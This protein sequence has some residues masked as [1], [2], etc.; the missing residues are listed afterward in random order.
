MV[1]EE[2]K[3]LNIS[4]NSLIRNSVDENPFEALD[5]YK[6]LL[7]RVAA[8]AR[9]LILQQEAITESQDCI[10]TTCSRAVF[11]NNVTL[12]EFLIERYATAREHI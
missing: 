5:V 9:N 4:A 10:L 6:Q 1:A 3:K 11:N 2:E 12:A 8:K 7:R